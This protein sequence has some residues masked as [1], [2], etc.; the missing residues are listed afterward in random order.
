MLVQSGNV[1]PLCKVEMS[2]GGIERAGF[3]VD[4]EP[5]PGIVLRRD[6][7]SA[8]LPAFSRETQRL[9]MVRSRVRVSCPQSMKTPKWNG[10]FLFPE[11]NGTML[12]SFSSRKP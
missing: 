2:P 8:F 9:V 5:A 7:H 11:N 10:S 1:T 12:Y 4:S 6:V 3:V